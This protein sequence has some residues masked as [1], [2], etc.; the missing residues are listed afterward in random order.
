MIV[1]KEKEYGKCIKNSM[2]GIAIGW[3]TVP[4]GRLGYDH[5]W[6]GGGN[7]IW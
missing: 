5:C 3:M 1:L 7:G 6:G 4:A 2:N